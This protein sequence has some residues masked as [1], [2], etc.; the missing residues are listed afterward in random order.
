MSEDKNNGPSWLYIL[1]GIVLV[2]FLFRFLAP[3]RFFILGALV[4]GSLG[5]GVYFLFRIIQDRRAERAF[6][7]SEEGVIQSRLEYCYRQLE[8]NET[9]MKDIRQSIQ[10]LEKKSTADDLTS[11]NR[12]ESNRL[13]RAF[14]SELELRQ[15]KV[16]FFQTCI[17]KLERLLNNHR[18]AREIEEKKEKLRLLQENH[19]EELAELEAL[20]SGMELD[21]DY[22]DTIETLS[23]QMPET[24]SLNDAQ[25]LSRELEE[26]TRELGEL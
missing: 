8:R 7:S 11:R 12:E 3:L 17:N 15:T 1:L 18:L 10:E 16:S 20:K 13:I 2:L 14:R 9:E 4:L 5:F 23:L 19:Y 22:L 6:R 26:M 25:R 24:S 21:L